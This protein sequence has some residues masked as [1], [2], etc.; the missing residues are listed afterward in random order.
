MAFFS[1]PDDP[2]PES[3]GALAYVLWV[4]RDCHGIEKAQPQ[5]ALEQ[6]LDIVGDDVDYFAQKLAD[7]YGLWIYDWPW[8]RFTELN[9]GVSPLFPFVLVWQ[10]A[11]WPL[12]GSFSYPSQFER[13]ELGHISR[14]IEAG[15]WIDP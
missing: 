5:M 4:A 3:E 6:E 13:L 14:V 7:R 11:T 2:P 9:E 12:R 15:E 8:Q 1:T 10:L